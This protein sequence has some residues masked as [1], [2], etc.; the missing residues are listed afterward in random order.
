MTLREIA[1]EYAHKPISIKIG[2]HVWS[3]ALPRRQT[4]FKNNFFR[5]RGFKTAKLDRVSNFRSIT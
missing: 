2:P 5:P 3:V 4:S 1:D